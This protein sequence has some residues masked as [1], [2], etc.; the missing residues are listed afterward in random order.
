MRKNPIPVA[1]IWFLYLCGFG[2]YLALFDG[3]LI[4]SE[5]AILPV[6]IIAIVFLVDYMSWRVVLDNSSIIFRSFFKKCKYNY[7]EINTAV[8]QYFFSDHQVFLV[9]SFLDGNKIRLK[10]KYLNFREARK[11][12]LK[13]ISIEKRK[14]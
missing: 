5:L 7:S 10:S 3:M 14:K 2:I 11:M 8:E 13:H 9:I 12:L 4:F 1:G 6:S